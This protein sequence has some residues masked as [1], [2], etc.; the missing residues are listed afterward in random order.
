MTIFHISQNSKKSGQEKGKKNKYIY[1]N[2]SN[3][4]TVTIIIIL[5]GI[6]L[7]TSNDK[8]KLGLI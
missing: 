5:S 8:R 1:N 7:D 2:N 4:V 6:S 3:I